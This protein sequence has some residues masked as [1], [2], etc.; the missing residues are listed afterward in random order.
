ML[1]TTHAII[2]WK[3]P[4]SDNKFQNNFYRGAGYAH[5]P[6]TA[7]SV[8]TWFFPDS[9]AMPG[10]GTKKAFVQGFFGK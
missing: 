1:T 2:Y 4:V 5:S 7:A 10:R 6:W 9:L 8:P 3:Y